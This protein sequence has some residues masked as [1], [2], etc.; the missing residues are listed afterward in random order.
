MTY[1]FKIYLEEFK[2]PEVW[3]HITVPADYSFLQF[4]KVI[5]T[6]FG[7][8]INNSNCF[9]SSEKDPNSL[10]TN[11]ALPLGNYLPAKNTLLSTVFKKRG[12]TSTYFSDING[13]WV[14]RIVLEKISSNKISYSDCLDGQGI[15]PPATCTNID[16]YKE[17]MLILSDKNHPQHKSTKE[18]L[19]L[20]ENESWEEKHKFDI[21]TVN[22]QLKHIDD[23]INLFRNYTI[24]KYDAFNKMYGLNSS[25]W[26]LINKKGGEIVDGTDK[27]KVLLELKKI[28]EQYPAIPHFKNLLAHAYIQNGEKEQGYEIMQQ[29]FAEY[30][31]FVIVRCGLANHY[32]NNG[33]L[34]KTATLLGKNFDLSELYPNRNNQFSENEIVS[35]H[36]MVFDY[37][38]KNEDITEAQKHFDYLEYHFP[39]EIDSTGMQIQL[40]LARL[41]E[42]KIVFG[43]QSSV[44]VIPEQVKSSNKAP[45]FENPKI[46]ILYQ[47]SVDIDRNIL[48][49]ILELPRESVIRDLEKILIDSIA[50]FDYFS[51]EDSTQNVPMHALL[52]LSTLKAEEA[53]DTLFTVLRQNEEYYDFWYGDILTED[54]WQFIYMMG[55]NKLDRL[56]DFVLEPNRYTFAR[57]TISHALM[58]IGFHQENRKEEVMK[59]FEDTIQSLLELKNDGDVFDRDV[60]SSLLDDFIDLAGK[61]QLPIILRLYDEKLVIPGCRLSLEEIKQY[62]SENAEDRMRPICTTIDQYYDQWQSWYGNYDSSDTDDDDNDDDYDDDYDFDNDDDFDN[63]YGNDNPFSLAQNKLSTPFNVKHKDVGRNDP[64]PCGS[65]KKYKKCCGGNK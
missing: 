8:K 25:L 33:Q 20:D 17:M 43:S 31:D 45:D 62:L 34:D 4:H 26:K 55:Q 28:V 60:Y 58:H 48:Y 41:K 64:C 61:E 51:K 10:I 46:K 56:K 16:D 18:W 9:F 19:D 22:K 11:V 54:F 23:E 21:L 52:L 12:Q 63:N 38:L 44:N 14:H 59:W 6:A 1:Q 40:R 7:N 35:Y 3:R 29:L 15:Y 53:L 5:A 49:R 32:T 30:P 65:G 24:V 57:S 47:Q 36:V 37:F 42:M 50:R 2:N 13:K 27:T 39:H